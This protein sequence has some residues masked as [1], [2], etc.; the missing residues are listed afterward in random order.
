MKKIKIIVIALMEGGL[1][2]SEESQIKLID[3]L[4][5]KR[6]N[7]NITLLGGPSWSKPSEII[8]AIDKNTVIATIYKIGGEWYVDRV[9]GKVPLKTI[10]KMF[11]EADPGESS[12]DVAMRYHKLKISGKI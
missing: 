7:L 2:P 1:A 3:R 6:D 10:T 11:S 12:W 4:F 8:K 9:E 5:P